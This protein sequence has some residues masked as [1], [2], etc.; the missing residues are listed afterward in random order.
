MAI[1][2]AKVTPSEG[3]S[4]RSMKLSGSS[5]TLSALTRRVVTYSVLPAG[6]D[7]VVFIGS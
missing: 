7:T 1:E 4:S 5:V 2:S 6:M 3:L